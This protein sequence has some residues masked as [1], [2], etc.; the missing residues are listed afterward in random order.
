MG[1]PRSHRS[2][3]SALIGLSLA[4]IS[5][6][7]DSKDD[8]TATA[9][10]PANNGSSGSTD[11][12]SDGTQASLAVSG[13]IALSALRLLGDATVSSVLAIAADGERVAGTFDEATG[14][15]SVDLAKD[16]DKNFV[17]T[18]L[19]ETQTGSAMVVA[20]V[21]SDNLST[22][23]VND[24]AEDSMELGELAVAAPA[25]ETKLGTATIKDETA[26]TAALGM[27][28][29]DAAALGKYD[30]AAKKAVNVDVD[31]DGTVDAAGDYKLDFTFNFS[32]EADPNQAQNT[33][34]KYKNAFL[35]DSVVFNK[36]RIAV[37]VSAKKTLFTAVPTKA[38]WTFA[39]DVGVDIS[40]SD[41]TI[42]GVT[43]STWKETITAGTA[44][45][46]PFSVPTDPNQQ[47]SDHQFGIFLTTMP[48]GTYKV[49]VGGKTLSFNGVDVKGYSEAPPVVPFIK[50]NVDSN[51]LITGVDY[52]WMARNAAGTGWELASAK[53]VE[54]FVGKESAR[55]S[56]SVLDN[57]V[58]TQ[59]G[60]GLQ[61]SPT[62]MTGSIAFNTTD[63]CLQDAPAGAAGACVSGDTTHRLTVSGFATFAAAQAA[64]FATWGWNNFT[65]TDKLAMTIT[66]N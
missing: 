50:F 37:T 45:E 24:A 20:T 25:D 10:N 49:V 13:K 17:V 48:H 41:V 6:G 31:G 51:D 2:L 54:M 11:D 14:E 8:P 40:G 39:E 16:A 1:L 46:M 19:D 47:G 52:K 63:G 44:I 21:V 34:S 23:S 28:T 22:I 27:T 56:M 4:A 35:S 29:E 5:C 58:K 43:K 65:F 64:P 62:T 36:G 59:K 53:L 57:G 60:F 38:T 7:K 66:A 26:V 61:I 3:V 15:F 30:A 12:G 9:S 18:L 42:G 32:T 33:V 55:F